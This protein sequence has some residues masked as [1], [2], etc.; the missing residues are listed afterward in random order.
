MAKRTMFSKILRMNIILTLVC[1]I[2]MG[3]TQMIMFTNY[4]SEQSEDYLSKNAETIISLIKNNISLSS[5]RDVSNG[6]SKVTGSYFFIIDKRGKVISCSD[7]SLLIDT[8]PL[9]LEDE[10]TKNVL[11]GKRTTFI[12]RMGKLF[13]ETMFTLQVPI[14][15]KNGEVFGA[16]SISRPIPEH[17]H[18]RSEMFKITFISFL[19]ILISSCVLSYLLAKT[20]S[21][22]VKNISIATKKFA[23]GDFSARVDNKTENSNVNEIAELAEAFNSMATELEKSDE[24]KNAFISDVSHELR[25]PMTTIGGFVSGIID[26]TI[27]AEKQKDYLRIVSDEV[28]RLSRLVNNFLDITRLQSDKITLNMTNFDINEL[29]RICII[30][31]EKKIDEKKIN[32]ELNLNSELCYVYADRDNIMRVMT[33]LID[34]ALKFTDSNG[35]IR[36]TVTSSQKDVNISVYNTGKGISEHDLPMIFNRFYKPDK[37]R[38]ENKEGTGIG[39]YL[40]KN[41]LNAHNQS[42]Y[43][44]STEGEYAEFYFRLIKGKIPNIRKTPYN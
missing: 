32:I 25:T 19:I 42:I 44:R 9:Y 2:V 20:F 5:L 38:S 36:I 26:D 40:V 24:I 3:S 21:V 34:N 37:S 6:F 33:N 4:I 22:P 31:F 30:S 10:Y 27:P 1:I 39:L 7:Q 17:R 15:E 23:K 41:I 35:L 29:I 18:M 28:S 12:G 14:K 11:S 43:V 16:V 13:N 8:P